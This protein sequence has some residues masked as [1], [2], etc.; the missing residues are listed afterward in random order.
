MALSAATVPVASFLPWERLA[1]IGI[2]LLKLIKKS[3]QLSSNWCTL[4]GEETLFE[5]V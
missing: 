4:H 5:R 1:G 2:V 3:V